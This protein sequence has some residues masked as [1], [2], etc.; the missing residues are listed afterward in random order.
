MG[1]YTVPTVV[2]K[3]PAGERV[4]DVFSRLLADRIISRLS[5]FMTRFAVG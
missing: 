2:E 5:Q 4:V 3:T 1:H